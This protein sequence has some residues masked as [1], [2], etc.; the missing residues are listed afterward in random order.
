MCLNVSFTQN[1]REIE[2]NYRKKSYN[3]R[4]N[5]GK[6]MKSI[7]LKALRWRNEQRNHTHSTELAE[8]EAIVNVI[9]SN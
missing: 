1:G 2:R 4:P 7:T 5:V 8:S 9:G 6:S 3:V